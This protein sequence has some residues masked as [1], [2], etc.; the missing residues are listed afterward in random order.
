VPQSG[1]GGYGTWAGRGI[2][3]GDAVHQ[4]PHHDSWVE[5]QSGVHS[6]TEARNLAAPAETLKGAAWILH[7]FGNGHHGFDV[8]NSVFLK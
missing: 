6:V 8:S 1:G 5:P 3:F 2:S 4:L 7:R